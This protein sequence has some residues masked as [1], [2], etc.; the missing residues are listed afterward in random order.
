MRSNPV[1]TV[2]RARFERLFASHYAELT[3]FAQ[4]RVGGDA[5]S[6]VV[7][8]TFL[9]AWRPP[10]RHPTWTATSHPPHQ[11]RKDA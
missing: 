1:E 9:V 6:D 5:A 4:R 10:T 2:A 3:R 8:E 7:A 11:S